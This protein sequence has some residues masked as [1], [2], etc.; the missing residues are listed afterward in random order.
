[1]RRLD[2]EVE[3]LEVDDLEIQWLEVEVEEDENDE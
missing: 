1:M 2:E 3:L